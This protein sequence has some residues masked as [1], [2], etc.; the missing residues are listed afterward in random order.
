MKSEFEITNQNGRTKRLSESTT[1]T[2]LETI[3]T[4]TRQHLVNTQNV[5]GMDTDTQVERVL[6]RGLGDV[7]VAA[8][9]GSFESFRRDLL[10]FV[11][12]H[13]D[14]QREFIDT[15]LLSAQIERTDL[16]V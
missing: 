7:L 9:T 12:N 5:E 15:G 8:N 14:G 11:R 1:H 13:M 10:V 4:G 16:G 6:S 2:G 3:G